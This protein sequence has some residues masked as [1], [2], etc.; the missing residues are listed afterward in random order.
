M[1]EAG[2][3]KESYTVVPGTSTGELHGLR[4]EGRT[5]V[6]HGMEHPFTLEYEFV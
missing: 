4:G 1:F 3:A 6:G 5:A 2:Q